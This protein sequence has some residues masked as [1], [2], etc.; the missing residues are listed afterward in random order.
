MSSN[1][2]FN[3][4]E[5]LNFG[6]GYSVEPFLKGGGYTN[7]NNKLTSSKNTP[8]KVSDIFKDK[9]IPASLYF[10]SVFQSDS[11]E[12][13]ENTNNKE[14]FNID[15]DVIPNDLYEKLL[16]LSSDKKDIKKKL[17]KD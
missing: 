14:G 7:K 13:S 5:L 15:T 3:S 11:K 9:A 12:D 10:N 8:N 2:L 17:L 16:L 6:N 4:D 1:E